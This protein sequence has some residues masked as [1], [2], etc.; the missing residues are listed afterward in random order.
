MLIL[1][2]YKPLPALPGV[3]AEY[4]REPGVQLNLIL[5]QILIEFLRPEHLSNP[6]QL[7]VVVVSVEERFLPEDHGGEH[8]TQRPHV[9]TVVVHLIIN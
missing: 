2:M 6:D 1:T 7:V 5:V 8:T 9:Q 4:I 3:S